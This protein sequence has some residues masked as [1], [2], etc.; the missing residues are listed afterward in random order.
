MTGGR[1]GVKNHQKKRDILYGRPLSAVTISQV[2]GYRL[3]I[4]FC[5][6]REYNIQCDDDDVDDD[7]EHNYYGHNLTTC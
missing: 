6:N 1:G 2:S 3:T 7:D 5:N 4:V